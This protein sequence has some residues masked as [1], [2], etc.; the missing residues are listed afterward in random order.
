[1]EK[2]YLVGGRYE[3][4]GTLGEGGMANVYLANDTLLNRKVAVKALRYDLQDDESV[5]RRFGREAKAT[6]GLS[7]PNI[8]NVLDVGNDNG[9]QYIVIEY[10]D[11]PNLK[12]YIRTHYPLSYH[13]VVDIMKQICMAVSDAH[14]HGIIHRDLKPENILVDEKKDPI[15]VKV[16]DF[17]IALALS[18][19]SITRTNSLLG[20][21][22]YMS[23]EQI[24][25][26]SATVLSDIYALGIILFELLTKHVPFTG[27]TA[28]TV[29]LKHSKEEIPDLKK[30]DP[31]IPQPLENAVLKATAKD[32]DQRYQSVKEMRDDL[33]TCLMPE[34]ANEPKFI[35]TP[36]NDL[37]ETRVMEPLDES[38]DKAQSLE[39]KPAKMSRKR[40]IILIASMVPLVLLLFLIAM[41]IKSNQETTVPDLYNLTVKQANVMLKSSNLTVG[42]VSREN[43]DDVNAGHV[44]KS[45]PTKGLKLKNGAK[46]NLVVSLGATYYKMPNLIDKQ[47]DDISDNLK[48]RGFKVNLKYKATNEYEAGSII[49]Q[50]I[51][52]GK[53]VVTKNKSL[54]LTLAKA[55]TVKPKVVKVRDLT[56]YNLKSI[57]DYASEAGLTL[58]TSYQYSDSIEEGLLVS[59]T[60]TANSTISV[61]GTLSVIISKGADPDKSTSNSK[62]ND[63][64][65]SSN[66]SSSGTNTVTKD[67]T[68]PYDS[69]GS[70]NVTIYISDATHSINSPYRTMTI[71]ADTPVTLSFNLKDGQT[72]SYIVERN[73]KTVLGGSVNG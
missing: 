62:D 30:I 46:V 4:L 17:G 26:R 9:V 21:V 28:V 57:Q 52:K 19:R 14:E 63:D 70:N 66:S 22:H 37:E 49:K 45:I 13:E 72:G 23:P 36:I 20:S 12:K 64:N 58:S 71:T 73:N 10:V 16:S 2:G 65:N 33:N 11:G 29:A 56:G 7:N 27:D 34:R 48:K 54:T 44:I 42:D 53:K 32:P 43:D 61:G 38:N 55:K 68:I 50:S 59:Q 39:K 6:S 24:K 67:I 47:Y 8:V 25:G 18:E 31:N 1:M 5:K 41:I 15:Q 51:P 35:P 60:P 40:K 69:S 3:I